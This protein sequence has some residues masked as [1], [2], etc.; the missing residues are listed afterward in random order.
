MLK[1]T[2]IFGYTGLKQNL[3]FCFLIAGMALVCAR[4]AAASDGEW[5]SVVRVDP[6]TGHLVRSVV[7]SGA[8]RAKTAARTAEQVRALANG[9]AETYLVDPVL[10]RSVIE[11]ESANNPGA[12]SPKGALGLMQLMPETA[13]RFGV[14]D[15]FDPR[16]NIA[17]GVRYLRY[18]RDLFQDD[19]LA[20]AAYNAGEGAVARYKGV[21]PY[22]ETQA[23]VETVSRKIRRAK[24]SQTAAA[25]PG[26]GAPPPAPDGA[27]PYAPLQ[28][29]YD[30]AG[31]LHMSTQ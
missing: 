29:Y 12:V 28:A 14:A 13:R 5:K 31:R 10:V 20:I 19:R 17:G 1:E 15:P 16:E 26:T 3:C 23:Y 24:K 25:G 22:K 6:K 2:I 8:S 7:A 30:S 27:G 21:P 9:A 18:L 11:A 4:S